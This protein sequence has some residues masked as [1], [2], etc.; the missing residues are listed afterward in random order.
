MSAGACMSQL[1]RAAGGC[2]RDTRQAREREVVKS[3]GWGRKRRTV[4][5]LHGAYGL[6]LN[7]L[8]FADP[9]GTTSRAVDALFT[10][11]AR[12][13]GNGL[14]VVRVGNG[15]QRLEAPVSSDRVFG[16]ERVWHDVDCARSVDRLGLSATGW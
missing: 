11:D 1:T 5:R 2:N 14:C 4:C 12:E 16:H 3:K 15:D 13:L 7:N 10:R 6:W 8:G 9:Y